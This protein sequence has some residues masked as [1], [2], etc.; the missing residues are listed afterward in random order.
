MVICFGFIKSK[1]VQDDGA[2]V[3]DG[4]KRLDELGGAIGAFVEWLDGFAPVLT[5]ID[6]LNIRATDARQA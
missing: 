1:C 6:I 3:I 5:I 4:L 2:L